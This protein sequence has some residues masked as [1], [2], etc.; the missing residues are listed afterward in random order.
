MG[1][2]RDFIENSSLRDRWT[3]SLSEDQTTSYCL[4]ETGQ[5]TAFA[6]AIMVNQESIDLAGC[7]QFFR[8][9]FVCVRTS[10]PKWHKVFATSMIGFAGMT[11]ICLSALWALMTMS[12]GM[13]AISIFAP[14]SF[15]FPSRMVLLW[16]DR[17]IRRRIAAQGQAVQP[18]RGWQGLALTLTFGINS[19]AVISAATLRRFIWRG[20]IYRVLPDRRLRIVQDAPYCPPASQLAEASVL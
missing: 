1:L 8:R 12:W 4:A 2:R 14:W 19:V 3:G 20:V 18:R 15:G 5:K 10:S 11:M 9:Q 17:N 7:F 6:P 13:A 16:A